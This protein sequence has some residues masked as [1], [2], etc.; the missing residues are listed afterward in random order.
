MPTTHINF[1]PAQRDKHQA[2]VRTALIE[3]CFGDDAYRHDTSPELN[4][5]ERARQKLFPAS[6]RSPDAEQF[7]YATLSDL[8]AECLKMDG[9]DIRGR[10]ADDIATAALGF[11]DQIGMRSS[12]GY[13]STGSFSIITQD[14]INKSMMLG[15]VE[16]PSTWRGPMRQGSSVADFKKIHRMQLGAVPNLPIWNDTKDPDVAS[17]ANEEE[18]YA[19]E[20]RSLALDFNYKTIVNGQLDLLTRVPMKLGDAAA[21][22]VNAFAWSQVLRNPLM[23]DGQKLF[24]APAGARKRANI[25]TGT[26]SNY[27]T[28]LQD[29]KSQMAQMRGANTPEGEEGHDT[30]NLQGRYLAFPSALETVMLQLIRSI[31]DPNAAHAGVFNPNTRLIP[32]MEPLLDAASQT[33]FYLFAEPTR[34]ETVEVTF[35]QGQ[36]EPK[37]RMILNERKLSQEHIVL[38]TFGAKA[39]DWRGMQYHTGAAE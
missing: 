9:Y 31:A 20:C 15:Y 22:T 10:S 12:N 29:L 24:S 6:E 18:T 35:L 8:A 11:G 14:A 37:T 17:F 4:F 23:R 5:R 7:R 13:H 30:L 19:V 25:K 26:V 3:Q 32:V 36:E 33:G 38:Q 2:A 21:R 1:G 28:A 27:T 34:C 16:F 39:L